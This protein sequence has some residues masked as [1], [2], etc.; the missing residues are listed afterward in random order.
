MPD[1]YVR[2]EFQLTAKI[3]DITFDDVV[4]FSATFGLN[5]IPTASLVVATGVNVQTGKLATIHDAVNNFKPREKATVTLTITTTDGFL[6]KMPQGKYVVFEG[7][8]AGMG[9]QRSS[10]NAN[11]TLHLIHWLDDLN[12]SSMLNG[13]WAVGVPHD[14]ATAASMHAGTMGVGPAAAAAGGYANPVP[15]VDRQGDIIT[16]ANMEADLWDKVL[17]PVF[18]AVAKFPHPRLRADE[19]TNDDPE[20]NGN[21]AAAILA[22]EKI[23]GEAPQPAKLKLDLCGLNEQLIAYSANMG[24]SRMATE[25]MGYTSFWGKLVGDFGASFLFA[26]SPGTTFA[27]VI[28]FFPGLR[29]P[30]RTITGDEYNAASFNASVA[31]MVESVDIFYSQQAGSGYSTGG[32]TPQPLSY[33]HPWGRFPQD[34]KEFRGQILIKEPPAWLSN[35]VPHAV[36]AS[37][38]TSVTGKQAGDGSSPG[39]GDETPPGGVPRPTEAEKDFTTKCEQGNILDRFAKHW[40]Q[41]EVLSQRY[42]ELSGKLRFDIAPGSVVRIMTP[43]SSLGDELPMIGTVTQVSV[44]INAEQHVAGTS[45]ALSNLRT[46]RENTD[47]NLTSR[48]APLYTEV[49]SGGHLAIRK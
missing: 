9:Y 21:N 11:Y 18:Q 5:S 26:V 22:L 30:W 29:S 40:Y 36:Y 49:W 17:K 23:P 31:A 38:S 14:L 43:N 35:P 4:A 24:I 20:Q 2:T 12:C 3:G 10:A 8:Y 7:Y 42:G 27:N 44:I 25:S 28:P 16:K 34:N 15:I 41:S 1:P 19:G 13:N 48:R 39:K 32:N 33:Y 46:Q 6:K 45:F 37:G 47:E